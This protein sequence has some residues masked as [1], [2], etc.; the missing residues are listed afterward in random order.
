MTPA[1]HV[2]EDEADNSPRDIVDSTSRRNGTSSAE[3]DRE[4]HVFDEG[5]GP[6]ERDQVCHQG[7]DSP[8]QE[9]P[10][11]T[12]VMKVSQNRM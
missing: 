10:D 2:V 6:F 5:V 9:E 4:V 12:A 8:D 1:N 11:K 7:T 3:D